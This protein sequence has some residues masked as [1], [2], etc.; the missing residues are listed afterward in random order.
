ALAW[1]LTARAA[2]QSPRAAAQPTRTSGGRAPR[3]T[4]RVAGA[5]PDAIALVAQYLFIPRARR[6]PRAAPL[7]HRLSR[8]AGRHAL[9]QTGR[10]R[11][12]RSRGGV[13]GSGPRGHGAAGS[14]SL[15]RWRAEL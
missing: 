13:V 7:R 14:R 12:A 3:R 2:G 1:R 11:R 4:P 10:Y 9:G 15:E 6:M 5:R 8:R